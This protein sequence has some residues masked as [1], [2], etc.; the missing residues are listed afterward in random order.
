MNYSVALTVN[1]EPW[2]GEVPAD[3]T[4]LRLLRERLGLTGTKA[5]CEMGECGA[6]TVLLEGEPVQSCLVLAV[7]TNGRRVE[8]VE[9]L[10]V[11]GIPHPL[12]V[13]FQAKKAVQCGFCTPGMLLAAKALLERNHHPSRAEIQEAL[14]GHLC[15]CTG[16]ENI[17]EAVLTAANQ[18]PESR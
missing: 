12:Q 1:G 4:L 7:E 6:C 16:Y 5:G 13:A 17:I 9:S 10:M 8:T 14:R 2:Q 11:N 18:S 3:L 15:R